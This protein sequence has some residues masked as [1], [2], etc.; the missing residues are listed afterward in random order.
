MK[1]ENKATRHNQEIGCEVKSCSHHNQ[2]DD[3]CTLSHIDVSSCNCSP[4]DVTDKDSTICKNYDCACGCI[5]DDTK[6]DE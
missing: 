6:K 3:T 1:K 4:K 2:D 5:D